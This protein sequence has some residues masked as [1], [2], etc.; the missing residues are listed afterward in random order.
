LGWAGE[1]GVLPKKGQNLVEFGFAAVI[2][3]LLVFGAV[4]LGLAYINQISLRAAVREGAIY[5]SLAPNDQ[6][7]IRNHVRGASDDPVDLGTLSDD[8]IVVEI[9]GEACAGNLIR[10]RVETEYRFITPFLFDRTIQLRAEA[11]HTIL[12][13]ACR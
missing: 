9:I 11:V 5:G 8:Q 12:T 2:L 1:G 6:V 4:D 7:G 13:P 10:V 3:I